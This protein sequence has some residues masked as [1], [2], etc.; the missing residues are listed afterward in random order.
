MGKTSPETFKFGDLIVEV[1]QGPSLPG[2]GGDSYSVSVGF[3]DGLILTQVVEI[4][5]EDMARL[6]QPKRVLAWNVLG[7]L[8]AALDDPRDFLQH[9]RDMDIERPWARGTF[10]KNAQIILDRLFERPERVTQVQ[11]AMEALTETMQKEHKPEGPTEVRIQ[12]LERRIKDSIE[13]WRK[14]DLPLDPEGEGKEWRPRKRRKGR[15]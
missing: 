7:N 5:P 2:I 14:L 10:W 6:I 12:E 11:E 15:K 1:S 13:H 8:E 9:A 3:P 4:L